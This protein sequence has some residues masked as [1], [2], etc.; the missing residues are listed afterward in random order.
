MWVYQSLRYVRVSQGIR[1]SVG[2][3]CVWQCIALN[4]LGSVITTWLGLMSLTNMSE[5]YTIFVCLSLLLL[6]FVSLFICFYRVLIE[7]HHFNPFSTRTCFHIYSTYYL[8]GFLQLQK[9]TWGIKAVQ[10]VAIH[11]TLPNVNK[12]T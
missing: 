12:I 5:D 10:S 4:S 8:T 2:V 6:F 9:L 1:C 7:R 11:Q 3:I